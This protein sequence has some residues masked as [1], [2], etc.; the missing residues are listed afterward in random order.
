MIKSIS[1]ILPVYNEQLRLKSAF[2]NILNFLK[3]GNFKTEIIFVD[4]GSTDN[5]L[6]LTR[7]DQSELPGWA[8]KRRSKQK[9]KKD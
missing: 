9:K 5:S 7:P 2:S 1:I 8:A 3:K 4:D 6:A